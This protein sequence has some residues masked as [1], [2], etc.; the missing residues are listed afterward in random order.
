MTA[1]GTKKDLPTACANVCLL[2]YSR[3]NADMPL[4]LSLTQSGSGYAGKP[5][6]RPDASTAF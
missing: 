2:G 4:L 5:L 3:L 1:P 6:L